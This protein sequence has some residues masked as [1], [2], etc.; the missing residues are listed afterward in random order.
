MRLEILVGVAG[1]AVLIA[2]QKRANQDIRRRVGE[3]CEDTYG[4]GSVHC[5][6]D[7]GT[8]CYNPSLG[9]VSSYPSGFRGLLQNSQL[10]IS[11]S[12]V[13]RRRLGTATRVNIALRLRDCAVSM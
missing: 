6:D 4:A 13:V 3:S 10:I 12:P 2:A 5:G 8:L 7:K 9:Q 11:I 1:Y